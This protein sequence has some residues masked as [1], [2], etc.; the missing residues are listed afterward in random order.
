MLLHVQLDVWGLFFVDT[1]WLGYPRQD[2]G[3][4]RGWAIGAI[5]WLCERYRRATVSKQ[6]ETSRELRR[7]PFLASK[8]STNIIR[9]Q[10]FA[11]RNPSIQKR[12]IFQSS[13]FK[14]LNFFLFIYFF[15]L[16]S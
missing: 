5:F 4:R 8:Y 16:C 9:E 12:S 7:L 2:T 1:Q 11:L 10:A 13:I 14:L 6:S 15:Y 3:E